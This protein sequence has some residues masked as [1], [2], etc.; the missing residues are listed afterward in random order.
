MNEDMSQCL[1]LFPW[2][3][4]VSLP[5]FFGEFVGCFTNY[6]QVFDKPKENY[7]IVL[8]CLFIVFAPIFQQDFY[9]TEYVVEA[10]NIP[11]FLSHRLIFYLC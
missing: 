7:W 6:F 3:F 11:Y 5:I 8:Y 9:R 2:N 1:N 10:T 4:I